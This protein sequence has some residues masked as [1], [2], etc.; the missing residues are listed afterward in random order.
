MPERLPLH[1]KLKYS[2]QHALVE[3]LMEWNPELL[4]DRV[5]AAE[6]AISE[7]IVQERANPDE[8]LALRSALLALEGVQNR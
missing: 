1:L 3:A 4:P 7:R 5:A 6:R 8:Q 2:W